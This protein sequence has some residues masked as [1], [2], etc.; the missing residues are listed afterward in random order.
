MPVAKAKKAPTPPRSDDFS[1]DGGDSSEGMLN[2]KDLAFRILARWPWIVLCLLLGVSTALVNVWRA[3]PLFQSTTTI[4]VRDSNSGTLGKSEAGDFDVENREAIETIRSSLMTLEMCEAIANEPRIRNLSHLIPLGPKP[5]PFL[6]D[7]DY[8]K[9]AQEV[10]SVPVLARLIQTWVTAGIRDGTRLIDIRVEHEDPKVAMELANEFVEQYDKQRI[11]KKASVSQ[12]NLQYLLGETKRVKSDLQEAQNVSASY[13]LP[14]ELEKALTV[15]EASA[16]SLSLRYGPLH[17]TM[18]EANEQLA[19]AREQLRISLLRAMDNPV[20]ADYW[21]SYRKAEGDLETTEALNRVRD[22]FIARHTV[23]ESEIESQN[24]LYSTMLS[25]METLELSPEGNSSEVLRQSA[26]REG[27]QIAPQ[28]SKILMTGTMGGLLLGVGLAFLLQFIDSKYHSPGDLESQFDYPVLAA[29]TD[30]PDLGKTSQSGVT[31]R[32]SHNRKSSP[33][34]KASAGLLF[35]NDAIKSNYLEMFRVLRTSVALLGPAHERKVT[36]VTSATPS[37]GKTFVAT[38]LAAAFAQQGQRTLLIDFDLRKPSVHKMFGHSRDQQAGLVELLVAKA[39]L[40]DIF[41]SCSSVKNLTLALSGSPAP[42]P[43]ELLESDRIK[44][45]FDELRKHFD[46]IVVDTA[47]VLPVPDS[48]LI[49]PLVDNLLLVVR[50]EQ[51][52]RGMVS[53]VLS[54]LENA[55]AGPEGIVLNGY[56]ERKAFGGKYSYG[57]DQYGYG[58]SYGDVYGDGS[59]STTPQ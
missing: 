19:S 31:E 12:E 41:Q 30:I 51:T 4:L 56:N 11:E 14:L 45:L 32:K 22:L 52:T 21:A 43:G 28:K 17:P 25:Q 40:G 35:A 58:S 39:Q 15:A 44:A 6:G 13:S 26:A 9:K 42:N 24:L 54:I 23:L 47:P 27:V 33:D 57:Y 36:M 2:L 20:D 59:S 29:I 37:E 3:S 10:P 55:N 18:R 48:R 46:Q 50:A 38:N 34:G 1:L 7:P 49:A 5:L 53:S 8:G 16:K